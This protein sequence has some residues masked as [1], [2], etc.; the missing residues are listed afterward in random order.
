MLVEI[1]CDKF[2]VQS[3]PLFTR[4]VNVV[5]GSD[6]GGNFIGKSTLMCLKQRE[7]VV[8]L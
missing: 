2:K 1:K 6:D 5:V 7:D 4:G 3:L 8:L